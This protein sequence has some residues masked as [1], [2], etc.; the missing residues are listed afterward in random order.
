MKNTA[1]ILGIKIEEKG[2]NKKN[3][4]A[5]ISFLTKNCLQ[6]LFYKGKYTII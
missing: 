2:K 1:D 4:Y 3:L 5:Q 6:T